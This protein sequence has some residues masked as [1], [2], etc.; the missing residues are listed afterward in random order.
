[1]VTMTP[2]LP[3]TNEI[4]LEMRDAAGEPGEGLEAPVVR[5]FSG[6]VDVGDVELTNQR[7]GICEGQAL[8]SQPGAWD[9]EVSLRL[10]E[11]DNPVDIVDFVVDAG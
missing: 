5:L 9:V 1:M 2:L 6:D 8:L 7:P 10:S 4:A 3:G 11:F